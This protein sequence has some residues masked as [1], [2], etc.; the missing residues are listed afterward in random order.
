M[1]KY[2]F[3]LI[4]CF[5]YL[6]CN[7]FAGHVA[8]GEIYYT[9]LG[10]GVA[11]NS[12]RYQITLR[13]FRECNPVPV[14]GVGLALLPTEVYIGIY[15]N[16][17]PSSR[18]GGLVNV[19]RKGNISILDLSTYD[20]CL[21]NK[22][23][24]C[25]QIALYEFEQELPDTPEGYVIGYQTCCRSNSIVNIE[26]YDIPSGNQVFHA[27]GATYTC[28]I[29]GTNILGTET[30]SSPVFH[31]KDTVLVC[32]NSSF[33]VDFSASDSDLGDSLS[34]EL[35]SAYDRGG[36]TNSADTNYSMPPYKTVTYLTSY[37]GSKPLGVNATID[38]VTGLIHG[39]APSI[40]AYVVNVCV[41][42]WRNGRVISTHRKDF[43]L[44]VTSCYLSAA[45]LR[46]AYLNCNDL[47]FTFFNE[48]LSSDIISYLWTFGDTASK[49]ADS[50]SLPVAKHEFSDTGVYKVRL[51]VQSKGGCVDSA[52]SLAKVYPGFKAK[53]KVKSSCIKNPYYFFDSTYSRYGRDTI[54]HWDFG[55]RNVLSDTSSVKNPSYIY[56]TI[57]TKTVTLKVID[58]NGCTDSIQQTIMVRDIP[59]LLLPNKNKDTIICIGDTIQL[60]ATLSNPSGTPVYA[61][62]PRDSIINPDSPTPWVHP[63]KT[64]TFYVHL[65]DDG[66]V[67]NDSLIIKTVPQIIVKAGPD[68][69]VCA[70]DSLQLFALTHGNVFIWKS[71]TG[72]RIDSVSNPFVKPS[73]NPTLYYVQANLGTKCF[74]RDTTAINVYPYPISFAGNDDAVCYQGNIQLRASIVGDAYSWYPTKTLSDSNTLSP[75][76]T[77]DTSSNYILTVY[78]TQKNTCPKPVSDTIR[79]SVI[80]EIVLNSVKDTSVVYNEPLQLKVT[81]NFDT[82]LINYQ[83]RNIKGGLDYLNST[84]IFNPVGIYPI[85]VDSVIYQVKATLSNPK[86]CYV[87][88]T[89]RV[90]VFKTP[91]DIF[92]PSAFTPNGDGKNDLE[93]PIPI[94]VLN[95]DYFNIYN[96]FGQLLFTTSQIG[97]GWDGTF[98]GV[99]QPAGT[100]VYMIQGANYLG[101]KIFKK[102]TVVLIR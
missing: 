25:Y 26:F 82:G 96:R 21:T 88:D 18:V 52:N 43:T 34:Y 95:L 24:V 27:D 6:T 29:P 70:S 63:K 94:G 58:N 72:E 23:P 60:M 92:V 48:S 73:A 102:G 78:Y 31:L 20:P 79:I 100:Y 80:P 62:S 61:W 9:Y 90:L 65:T 19:K 8:G 32:A 1:K 53:I 4:V 56:P 76:I 85:V 15:K 75:I 51:L 66:C 12:S 5:L 69:S 42:E 22:I 13:L 49:S 77:P 33:K 64:S 89:I 86:H 68:T 7:V 93:K 46:P 30:N 37:S 81:S 74:A 10:K 50:S 28:E 59:D 55:E 54:W 97:D 57:G 38:P 98:N 16:T 14:N 39:T 36:T 45:D 101:K 99:N 40:G 91:P 44:K 41:T 47:N 71:N 83:W 84:S 2:I 11:P 3:L 17:N 87:M 35:C 67:A